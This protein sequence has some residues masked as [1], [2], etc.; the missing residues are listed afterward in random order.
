MNA[1]GVRLLTVAAAQTSSPPN[2]EEGL[3]QAEAIID[4]AG[5]S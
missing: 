5:A 4:E 3:R 2:V 1:A